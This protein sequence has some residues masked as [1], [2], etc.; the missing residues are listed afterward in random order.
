[1]AASV[2]VICVLIKIEI[3]SNQYHVLFNY[4]YDIITT[5][6]TTIDNF[7]G[8]QCKSSAFALNH[9]R[10]YLS[11]TWF[12]RNVFVFFLLSKQ[13]VLC[14]R[15]TI[16]SIH[17]VFVS[18]ADRKKKTKYQWKSEEVVVFFFFCW[19][20]IIFRSNEGNCEKISNCLFEAIKSVFVLLL[21]G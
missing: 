7:S 18:F 14:W 10:T 3:S 20:F 9:I 12:N 4:L 8:V 6:Q 2:C 17:Y 15:E 5:L 11:N 21:N 16:V 1:M 13:R 19:D